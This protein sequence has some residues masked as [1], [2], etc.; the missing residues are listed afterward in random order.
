MDLRVDIDPGVYPQEIHDANKWKHYKWESYGDCEEL[1]GEPLRK[2]H[3]LKCESGFE[4]TS[5]YDER[6]KLHSKQ[7]R[8]S[9]SRSTSKPPVEGN[10]SD[11]LKWYWSE[12][13]RK[14]SKSWSRSLTPWRKFIKGDEMKQQHQ[15]HHVKRSCSKSRSRSKSLWRQYT[16]HHERRWLQVINGW[17]AVQ[18]AKVHLNH[19]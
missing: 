9:R 2:Y 7:Y 6:H 4:N 17:G 19:H 11:E 8:I 14:M 16:H 15:Q 10:R 13:Y 18:K 12:D 1:S 3:R 5:S